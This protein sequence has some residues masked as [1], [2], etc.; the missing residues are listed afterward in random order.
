LYTP[1]IFIQHINLYVYWQHILEHIKNITITILSGINATQAS[2]A[3]CMRTVLDGKF[4]FLPPAGQK[5]H[6]S[7]LRQRLWQNVT[8]EAFKGK[9]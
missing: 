8:F 1:Y 6:F 9:T 3:K 5:N 2:I 4:V 7:G